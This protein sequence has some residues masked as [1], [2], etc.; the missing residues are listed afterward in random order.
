MDEATRRGEACV[1]GLDWRRESGGGRSVSCL[2]AAVL[3]WKRR[4]GLGIL[5][6]QAVLPWLLDCSV[7]YCTVL[8]CTVLCIL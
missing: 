6:A 1:A 5:F 7:L 2:F 8:Y 4:G 3:E